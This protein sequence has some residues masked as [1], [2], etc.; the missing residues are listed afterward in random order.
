MTLCSLCENPY[1]YMCSECNA[2]CT[3]AMC[4]QADKGPAQ[5]SAKRSDK[6]YIG[7]GDILPSEVL[8]GDC[9]SC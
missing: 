9:C 5:I 6:L 2:D 7:S 3:E 1:P 8:G 4:Q